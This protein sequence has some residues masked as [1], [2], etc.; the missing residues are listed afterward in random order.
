MTNK[1]WEHCIPFFTAEECGK[2]MNAAFMIKV[3]ALRTILD[4]PMHV[5][6]GWDDR[7]GYHGTGEALDWWVKQCPR[8]TMRI[9][10]RTAMLNGVGFYP[11]GDHLS[12]HIDNRPSGMYQ[13]WI[14]PKKGKYIYLLKY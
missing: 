4:T 5:I 13:R 9:I 2:K 1:Q 14:S 8:K 3:V 7:K 12:F 10:D 6:C 11:W